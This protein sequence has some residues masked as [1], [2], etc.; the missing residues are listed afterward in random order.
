MSRL[1]LMGIEEVMVVAGMSK[2][3]IYAQMKK[4]VFQVASLWKECDLL[5][6]R[7]RKC[8][9]S[10]P[11]ELPF[12]PLVPSVSDRARRKVLED[13]FFGW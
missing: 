1:R 11:D 8:K 6:G 10:L 2:S 13:H 12:A 4:G 3:S 5:D 7:S 9:L